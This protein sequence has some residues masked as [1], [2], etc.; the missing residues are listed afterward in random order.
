MFSLCKK[1]ILFELRWLDCSWPVSVL[2][3]TKH[4]NNSVTF[5]KK[6]TK[7]LSRS[8]SAG[9]S[10]RHPTGSYYKKQKICQMPPDHKKCQDWSR[11]TK[12][13]A[14]MRM[15]S[16]T[17]LQELG[18]EMIINVG[19]PYSMCCG[20]KWAVNKRCS[21]FLCKIRFCKSPSDTNEDL[22]Y[23]ANKAKSLLKSQ[24]RTHAEGRTATEALSAVVCLQIIMWKLV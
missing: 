8:S 18:K 1:W 22:V 7:I 6:Q 20:L 21:C 11:S 4:Q 13:N 2:Q 23:T 16:S 19:H 3:S 14:A 17:R 15:Y 12:V 9:D 10:K 5:S 24:T